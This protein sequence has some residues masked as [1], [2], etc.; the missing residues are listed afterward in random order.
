MPLLYDAASLEGGLFID[1]FINDRRDGSELLASLDSLYT[2]SAFTRG[3]HFCLPHEGSAW[4][5]DSVRQIRMQAMQMELAPKQYGLVLAAVL[6]KKACNPNDFRDL[7]RDGV[8]NA[9]PLT[10]E[11]VRALAYVLAERILV[12]LT[13]ANPQ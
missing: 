1:G 3:D 9:T 4:F 12:A 2:A 5:T 7:E 13:A 6:L 11:A 10:R 8:L